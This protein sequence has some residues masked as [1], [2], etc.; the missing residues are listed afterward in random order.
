MPALQV[1]YMFASVAD[2]TE[3][4]AHLQADPGLTNVV[5]DPA[6]KRITFDVPVLF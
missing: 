4:L 1:T 2:Y 6:T 3:A 5:G